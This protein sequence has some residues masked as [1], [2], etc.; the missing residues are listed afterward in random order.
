MKKVFACIFAISLMTTAFT[1]VINVSPLILNFKPGGKRFADITVSN[2]GEQTAYVAVKIAKI[3]NPGT[4]DQ[5]RVSLKGDPMQFGLVASP[6][7][8]VIPPKQV[9]R[10][11]V[12]P[13][14]H[15]NTTDA[16]YEINITPVSGKIE[17]LLAGSKVRA[18][19]QIIVGYAVKAFIRPANA[20]AVVSI[21]RNNK[22][23]TLKNTGNSNVLLYKGEQ[24]IQGQCKRLTDSVHRLYAGNTWTFTAPHAAPVQFNEKFMNKTGVLKSN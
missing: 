14:T 9:R 13:L 4:P 1:A 6:V 12:L 8:M 19:L 3:V 24:C 7:R 10:V 5:K 16:M 20:K 18:G 23:V 22:T 17:N 11:R 15:N 21:L 2:P